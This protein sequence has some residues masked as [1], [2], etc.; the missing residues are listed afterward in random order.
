MPRA[1]SIRTS[2]T[3]RSRA[4]SECGR[5]STTPSYA[6]TSATR[7]DIPAKEDNMHECASCPDHECDVLVIGAGPAGLA[8]AVNAA[9][10]G[11]RVIVLERG[12]EAGGQASTS[13][14]I[15]NYLGFPTGLT[16]PEL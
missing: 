15:E 7:P 14:R 4:S 10:E 12:R 8:A 5:R 2:R 16:G 1:C 3:S 11:L 9:S 13:S 6:V